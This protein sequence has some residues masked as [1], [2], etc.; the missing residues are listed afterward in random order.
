[1]SLAM[2]GCAVF[3][4]TKVNAATLTVT[5]V[6]EIGRRPGESI[7]YTFVFTPTPSILTRIM[8]AIFRP[9]N[10]ELS[11]L[12]GGTPLVLGNFITTPTTFSRRH[13]VLTPVKDGFSDLSATVFYEE[14]RPS[15]TATN[16]Q[17]SAAGAD[18]VPEPVTLLGTATALGCGVLFK[19]K[20]SKKTV[21]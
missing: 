12:T 8:G 6:G 20:S 9:D 1:M 5:P 2:T 14:S 19:R 10:S 4:P 11:S 17:I 21:S 16:L 15:G 13:T 3:M 7:E 18:V